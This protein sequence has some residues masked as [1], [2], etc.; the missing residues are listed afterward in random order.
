VSALRGDAGAWSLKI[1]ARDGAEMRRLVGDV[2]RILSAPLP[3]M[4]TSL[5]KV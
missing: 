2:R 5:R 3:H 1:V 4:A